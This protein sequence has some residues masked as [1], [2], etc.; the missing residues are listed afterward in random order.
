MEFKNRRRIIKVKKL[1]FK[2]TQITFGTILMAISTTLF[3]LPNQLSSGGFSGISTITYYLFGIPLGTMVIILN[4][5]LFII[6]F[7]KNGKKFF[8]N[9]IFGTLLLSLFLNIFER[10][11][12]LTTD[13]ILGCIYGGIISGIGSAIIFKAGA[14]TGRNRLI[15]SNYK[16]FQT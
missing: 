16:G 7:I 12:P 5:P 3:L 8:M 2:G 11:K 14:S 4:I 6:A 13:R 10:F 15:N 9:A 1:V